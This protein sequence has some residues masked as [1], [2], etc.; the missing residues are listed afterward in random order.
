ME[1]P[2]LNQRCKYDTSS[3]NLT[4]NW[5]H[6]DLRFLPWMLKWQTN[7]SSPILPWLDKV[8]SSIL[9]IFLDL[10]PACCKILNPNFEQGNVEGNSSGV[11]EFCCEGKSLLSMSVEMTTGQFLL[12]AGSS[13][14][15]SGEVANHIR[16]VSLSSERVLELDLSCTPSSNLC[17][18]E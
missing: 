18:S 13:V 7:N 9:F 2:C 8:L 10:R 1:R 11:L 15:D 12:R 4:L 16:T 5:Y 3:P 6:W 14:Q 17:K